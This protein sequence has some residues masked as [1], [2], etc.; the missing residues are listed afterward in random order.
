MDGDDLLIAAAVAAAA[1]DDE[2]PVDLGFKADVAKPAASNDDGG[3]DD[4]AKGPD[5]GEEDDNNDDN[6]NDDDDDEEEEEEAADLGLGEEEEEPSAAKGAPLRTKNELDP[7]EVLAPEPVP[8]CLPAGTRLQEAA[9]VISVVGL[10][11]VLRA[12]PGLPPLAEGSLLCLQTLPDGG[13]GPMDVAP[14]A[15]DS[16]GS[17]GAGD[18]Q[19]AA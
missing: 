5:D 9:R 14:D 6:D 7:D 19:A 3:D 2:A 11:V 18:A 15:A 10:T 12:E 16:G 17:G 1:A 4:A 13:A 8:D